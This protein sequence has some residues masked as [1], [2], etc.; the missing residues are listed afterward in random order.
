GF[1]LRRDRVGHLQ[2]V[3]GRLLRPLDRGQR[4]SVHPRHRHRAA[5]VLVPEPQG[6]GTVSTTVASAPRKRPQRKNYLLSAI[7]I[8]VSF[9]V[10]VVPFLFMVVNAF[11]NRQDASRLGFSW[12]THFQFVQNF[13]EVITSRDYML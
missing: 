9:V 10:F 12:P 3:P 2:A 13:R 7:G 8:V 1:Q 4:D 6:G 5:A 11:K